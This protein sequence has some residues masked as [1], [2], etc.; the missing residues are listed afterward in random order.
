MTGPDERPS[1]TPPKP[2][3]TLPQAAGQIAY[4]SSVYRRV[5]REQ[6]GFPTIRIGRSLRVDPDALRLWMQAQRESARRASATTGAS[7]TR[8]WRTA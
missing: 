5:W 1:E 7:L 2:L 4:G 8:R 3:L 6:H